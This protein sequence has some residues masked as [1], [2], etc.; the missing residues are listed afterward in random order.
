MTGIFI[1]IILIVRRARCSA[2][3]KRSVIPR[4][5]RRKISDY[6]EGEQE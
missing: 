1:K 5:A 4:Y 3:A 6:K 2:R